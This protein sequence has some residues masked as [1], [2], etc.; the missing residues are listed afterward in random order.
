M[1]VEHV[2]RRSSPVQIFEEEG[3]RLLDVILYTARFG[4]PDMQQEQRSKAEHSIARRRPAT[5]RRHRPRS[6]RRPECPFLRLCAAR[7]CTAMLP[8]CGT[9]MRPVRHYPSATALSDV[10]QR[11]PR[12]AASAESTESMS[13]PS[14]EI[15]SSR[16]HRVHLLCFGPGI[17]EMFVGEDRHRLSGTPKHF[18][19]GSIN[20]YRG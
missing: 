20:S 15:F 3:S 11:E 8:A 13:P 18:T 9:R 19:I 2:G 14:R 16:D 12:A 1:P 10:A 7:S 4:R 6:T 5:A 17:R